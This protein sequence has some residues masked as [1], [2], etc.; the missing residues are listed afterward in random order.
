MP[1]LRLVGPALA[2][3]CA[4]GDSSGTVAGGVQKGP[5]ILG[6]SVEVA[7]VNGA[8]DPTGQVF[9]TATT[10]D[11]GDFSVDVASGGLVSIQADGFYYNEITGG[12]SGSPGTLRAFAEAGAPAYVNPVTHLTHERVHRL[13]GD[14]MGFAAAVHQAEAE[15]RTA[16]AIAPGFDPG[17]L[18]TELDLM[19]GDS[20]ANAYLLAAS[21]VLVQAAMIEGGSVD[22]TVQQLAN[23]IALDLADDGAVSPAIVAELVT[24]QRAVNTATVKLQLA[25]RFAEIGSNAPVPDLDRMIDNDGDGVLN[26]AD[27]CRMFANADQLD[28]DSDGRGDPCSPAT[29]VVTGGDAQAG[30]AH[31]VLAPLVATVLDPNANPVTGVTVRFAVA[32]GDGSVTAVAI[33]DRHG[34]AAATLTLGSTRFT[35]QVIEATIDGLPGSRVQFVA[36]TI[37]DFASTDVTTGESPRPVAIGDLNRDGRPDVVAANYRDSVAVLLS[38]TTAGAM[39]ATYAP[40]VDL[41]F[42][43]STAIAI[44]DLDGDGA[45]DLVVRYNEEPTA[46]VFLERIAVRLNTTPAGSSIASFGPPIDIA[47]RSGG[48][49]AQSCSLDLGDIDGDGR[50]DIV[51]GDWIGVTV[52]INTTTGSLASFDRIDL[53]EPNVMSAQ[54]V[55]LDQDGRL[56]IVAVAWQPTVSSVIALH[57][58]GA[59]S[60]SRTV[61]GTV[62]NQT[63]RVGIAN[64]DFDGN[65]T[66]DL[67]IT[68][69]FAHLSILTN[70]TLPGSSPT[71]EQLGLDTTPAFFDPPAFGFSPYGV[72]VGD[73]DGDGR[74]DLAFPQQ[75]GVSVMV[76]TTTAGGAPTF[77]GWLVSR[78]GNEIL[79]DVALADFNADGRLDQVV[80]TP[81]GIATLLAR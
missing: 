29:L 48:F 12:L 39:T 30:V 55:D 13:L 72:A 81:T 10:N 34:R 22:A 57:N 60:F 69:R 17:V 45:A 51:A 59:T 3:L 36:D 80:T 38:T 61:V 58:D 71:F 64:G 23:T 74:L 27:N 50:L 1:N 49:G 41:A 18:A 66:P 63:G 43:S 24:A 16:L 67:A 54:L 77:S 68:D 7:L 56:D 28:G 35:H 44:G 11:R 8:G 53:P 31:G 4:C 9:A 42:A 76:N 33:S 70:T 32:A 19:G 20:D 5:Y 2:L 14:G 37:V 62:E 65:G 52:F 73:L 21:C 75:G 47:T 79:G 26:H 25:A 15:L 78:H 46:W 6:T 40:R